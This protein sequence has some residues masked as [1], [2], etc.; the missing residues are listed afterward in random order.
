MFAFT[1]HSV[2]HVKQMQDCGLVYSHVGLYAR[3][4][5]SR[6]R[7][8]QDVPRFQERNSSCAAFLFHVAACTYFGT[9][10]RRKFF[11]EGVKNIAHF[12]SL[13]CSCVFWANCFSYYCEGSY[14]LDLNQFGVDNL[15]QSMRVET[16]C[17]VLRTVSRRITSSISWQIHGLSRKGCQILVSLPIPNLEI[18][19]KGCGSCNS[20]VKGSCMIM[21]L[22][23][24][25]SAVLYDKKHK[26]DTRYWSLHLG[27]GSPKGS[28]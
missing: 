17:H 15:A 12:V 1:F 3:V 22:H 21:R 14:F 25:A 19:K 7:A 13:S 16:V 18:L 26:C 10:K 2:P 28:A 6:E 5:V 27:Q 24:S 8:N 23:K 20:A 9:L 4:P 11:M